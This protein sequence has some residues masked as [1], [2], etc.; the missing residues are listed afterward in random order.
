M[1][2]IPLLMI[3]L[4]L[5]I[6]EAVGQSAFTQCATEGGTCTFTGQKLI[7]YGEPF[8]NR[9]SSIRTMTS[10]VGCNNTT[11]SPDPS[12]GTGKR[13]EIMDVPSTSVGK[14]VLTWTQPTKNT[15]GTD[16]VGRRSYVVHR[17]AGQAGSFVAIA[18]LPEE[19]T[20]WSLLAEPLGEQCYALAA[21]V[22]AT[23]SDLSNAACK[24]VRLPAP[25][26]GRIEAPS[27]GAIEPR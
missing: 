6:H 16:I 18:I 27:D 21:V 17:R 7:R 26:D 11:F 14:V 20:T 10:P 4:G 15:D 12:P 22:N 8:N 25:S 9:W 13:C 1:R 23:P 5:M 2:A 3:V 19:I 24:V